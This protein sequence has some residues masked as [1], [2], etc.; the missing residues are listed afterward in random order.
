MTRSGLAK[1]LLRPVPARWHAGKGARD[2]VLEILLETNGFV[3]DDYF[4]QI[5]DTVANY[6]GVHGAFLCELGL[7]YEKAYPI[8][9][10]LDW[11][12]EARIDYFYRSGA[13]EAVIERGNVVLAKAAHS[14]FPNDAQL[15][16]LQA[17]AC[18]ATALR[19]Q[20]GDVIGVLFLVH[21]DPLPPAS[22]EAMV[23]DV[24]LIDTVLQQ[25]APRIG[26]ELERRQ[27][28]RAVHR[29]ESRLRHL[30]DRCKDVLFY[31]QLHPAPELQY[32][33]P[34]VQNVFGLPPEAFHANPGIMLEMMESTDRENLEQVLTSGSEEPLIARV[35]RPDGELRWMEYRDFAV[36]DNQGT[37]VGIGGTIRDITLRVQAEEAMRASEHYLR[38]LVQAIPDSLMLLRHDGEIVDYM[39]GEVD[40]RLPEPAMCRGRCLRD[41][42][43]ASM[44]GVL[45]R[46]MRV[47]IRTH[48]TQ[49]VEFEM[50]NEQPQFFDARCLPF[51]DGMLLLVLR[52]LTAQKWHEAEPARQRIRDEVNER[53]EN[54]NRAN[55][56]G[57]TYR[58]LAVLHL[59]VEGMAD[60]QIA[61]AL[62]ISIYTVN[63][64]VGNV[65]G[66]MN[67]V[68]RTEAGVRA[69]REGLL[70]RESIA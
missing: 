69:V 39:P 1:A 51:T 14:Q 31:Y 44:S 4:G 24:S 61:D 40:L 62:G 36:R 68:S 50:R 60:K 32:I 16:T 33:S 17:E 65:L 11:D 20:S 43:P 12:L 7:D 13:C 8:S 18:I 6:F 22:S 28:E 34:A 58:E 35:H 42:M 47:T 19:A 10:Y 63:K 59:V 3:G 54:R 23:P 48:R 29:S 5:T 67:A 25:L 30:T 37:L 64:H 66:K 53:I 27:Q 41:V 15:T 38:T 52:D 70:P 56:Y 57:L 21:R 49:R 45:E 26:A 2:A 46:T 55:L 9:S